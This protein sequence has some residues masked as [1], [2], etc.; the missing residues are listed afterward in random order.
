M[1][2]HIINSDSGHTRSKQR[3][4]K[5]LKIPFASPFK[6]TDENEKDKNKRKSIA[7]L[8]GW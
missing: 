8:L 7:N 4:D 1:V 3:L 2:Y 6:S 5:Y